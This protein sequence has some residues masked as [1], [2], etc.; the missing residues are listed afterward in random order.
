MMFKRSIVWCTVENP[1]RERPFR[2][3]TLCFYFDFGTAADT[4][5]YVTGT[6]ARAQIVKDAMLAAE[7][8]FKTEIDKL[9]VLVEN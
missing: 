4:H 1:S 6:P 5:S 3:E 9:K 7:H 2:E 8:A